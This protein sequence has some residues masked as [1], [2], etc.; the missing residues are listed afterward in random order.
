[1]YAS[2]KSYIFAKVDGVNEQPLENFVRAT[3]DAW[4]KAKQVITTR[5]FYS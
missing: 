3:F 2:L 5:P 4:K 1:M